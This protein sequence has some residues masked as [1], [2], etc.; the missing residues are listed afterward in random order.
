[1]ERPRQVLVVARWLTVFGA[2]GEGLLVG[3]KKVGF[4]R[5]LSNLQSGSS[6]TP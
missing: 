6:N 1:V 4:R 5:S 2:P 3:S